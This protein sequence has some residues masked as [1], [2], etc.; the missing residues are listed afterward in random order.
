M[1]FHTLNDLIHV[2]IIWYNQSKRSSKGAC[3]RTCWITIWWIPTIHTVVL[4]INDAFT[5]L[6]ISFFGNITYQIFAP[7]FETEFLKYHAKYYNIEDIVV[8]HFEENFEKSTK[9]FFVLM[10]LVKE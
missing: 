5:H 4:E 7:P 3:D 2:I 1:C 8:F 6:L 9:N 10:K